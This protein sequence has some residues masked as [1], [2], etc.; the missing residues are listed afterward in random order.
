[1]SYLLARKKQALYVT[2]VALWACL[3]G[4]GMNVM[5]RY[6]VT[7][8]QAAIPKIGWPVNAPVPFGKARPTLVIFAHPNCPYSR[9]SIGELAIQGDLVRVSAKD[10]DTL[11][12]IIVLL[13][14]KDFGIDMQFTNY[15]TN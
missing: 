4:S 12:E 14:G 10:R 11:Q 15:R 13:K 7:P 2:A 6:S 1:M 8:G 5:W 9:A 3:V